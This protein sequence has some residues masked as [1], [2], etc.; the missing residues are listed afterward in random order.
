MRM[1]ARQVGKLGS[2]VAS[3][4]ERRAKSLVCW[5]GLVRQAVSGARCICQDAV[6]P[7][8]RAG[9]AGRAGRGKRADRRDVCELQAPFIHPSP[10]TAIRAYRGEQRP[11]PGGARGP[12][13]RQG[14][15]VRQPPAR[16]GA[17]RL[18]ADSA[19]LALPLHRLSVRLGTR[20][21]AS[22]QGGYGRNPRAQVCLGLADTRGLGRPEEVMRPDEL[23]TRAADP[24]RP[25]K[26]G[27]RSSA[28]RLLL[29]SLAL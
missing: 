28:S 23:A 16:L 3:A 26:P 6:R 1:V 22:A 17:K 15:E 20:H 24:T 7:R 13:S 25:L 29:D 8:R 19:L 27:P 2:Q 18:G 4:A 10:F 21:S 5:V 11:R 9:H 12:G 14:D